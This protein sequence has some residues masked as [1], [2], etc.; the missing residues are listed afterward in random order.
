MNVLWTIIGGGGLL[1][2]GLAFTIY[3]LIRKAKKV[4]ILERENAELKFRLEKQQDIT[5]IFSRPR[6]DKS[7]V[8]DRL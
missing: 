8:I 6:G 5:D 1:S 3:Q 4:E 7:D 2:L